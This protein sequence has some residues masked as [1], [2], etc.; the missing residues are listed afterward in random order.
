MSGWAFSASIKLSSAG[1]ATTLTVFEVNYLLAR[2]TV[3][4]VMQTPIT[5]AMI[6]RGK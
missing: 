6:S 5:V 4:E 1:A 2:L 3:R